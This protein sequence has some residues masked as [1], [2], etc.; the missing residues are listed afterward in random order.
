MKFIS[1]RDLRTSPKQIWKS[2]PDE[3]EMVVT[4]NG[5]PIAL[6]TPIS[7]ETLE[8]TVR[9]LRR[10]R[11]MNA[12]QDMQLSSIR[13]GKDELSEEEI[14]AEIVQTRKARRR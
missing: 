11:A 4:N 1:V 8:D 6:L 10:V 12:V 2:L 9:A 5:R 13:K 7:D 14:E 3:K